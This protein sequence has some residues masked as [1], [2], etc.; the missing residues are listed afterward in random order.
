MFI[1]CTV[2]TQHVTYTYL[3]RVE[4][5]AEASVVIDAAA[6]AHEVIV[7]HKGQGDGAVLHQRQHHDLLVTGAEEAAHVVVLTDIGEFTAQV[8]VAG[9]VL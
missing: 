5:I 8:S 3:Q 9:A 7:D 6:V 4:A 1:H 2:T